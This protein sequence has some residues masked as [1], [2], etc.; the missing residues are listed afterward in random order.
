V[1]TDLTLE[2]EGTTALALRVAKSFDDPKEEAFKRIA[3]AVAKYYVCKRAPAFV[4][5]CLECLGGNGFVEDFPLARFFRQ[6]PLNAVWEGSGNVIVADVFRAM[7]KDPSAFSAIA[8]EVAT[9]NDPVISSSFAIAQRNFQ[10]L[11]TAGTAE[12]EGRR[13]VEHLAVV[14]QACAVVRAELPQD[15]RAAFLSSRL[16]TG[17][18]EPSRMAQFGTLQNSIVSE[19]I[20]LRHVPK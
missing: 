16:G 17:V 13:L 19:K 11:S 12:V 4:Y 10:V 5:E 14:L 6:S 20:F 9:A 2:V 1:L 3:T 15:V 7:A 8:A 18:A